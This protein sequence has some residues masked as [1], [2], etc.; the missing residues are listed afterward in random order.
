MLT[1]TNTFTVSGGVVRQDMAAA[2][3]DAVA[4]SQMLANLAPTRNINNDV[5][6]SYLTGNGGMNIVRM[7]SLNYQTTR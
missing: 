5:T 3:N 1:C 6:N 4:A 7:K 2:I